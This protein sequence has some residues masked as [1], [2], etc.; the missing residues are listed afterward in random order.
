M[1]LKFIL[2]CA[3][4]LTQ[5][6]VAPAR[7]IQIFIVTEVCYQYVDSGFKSVG[8]VSGMGAVIPKAP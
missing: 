7:D 4:P 3:V 6:A 8:G 1:K 2:L 5:A